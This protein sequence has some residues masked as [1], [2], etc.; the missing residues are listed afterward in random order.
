M[1]QSQ[2]LTQAPDLKTEQFCSLHTE[3]TAK[4]HKIKVKNEQNR[5]VCVLKLADP[6]LSVETLRVNNNQEEMT[7]LLVQCA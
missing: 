7:S 5:L 4:A 6:V 1:P 3:A 2:L